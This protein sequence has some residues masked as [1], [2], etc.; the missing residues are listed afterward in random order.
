MNEF[1][2]QS[3]WSRYPCGEMQI[4]GFEKYGNKYDV[5]FSAYDN[6]R[7]SREPHI[8][9]CLD[10]IDFKGK[11]TLE[12]GLGLGADS[13]Q[14]IRR[15]AIWSG[16]DLTAESVER[17]RIRFALRRLPFNTLKQGSVLSIPFDANSFDI[18]FSHGVL[19]HV[20][21]IDRAQSEIF[22]VLKSGGELIVMLYSKISL[23]YLM[24]ISF[25]RRL[26]LLFL[27]FLNYDPGGIYGQHIAN[28]RA[29]G[30]GRYLYMRNFIHKNTDGPLNPYSKVYDLPTVK[31]AFSNFRVVRAYKQFMHAPPL[32]VG[33]LPFERLL[34][35][36]L[37]V[38]MKPL[39]K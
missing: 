6:F 16:I 19:H 7:Y 39:K 32:P 27:Y 25:V 13:E 37:W 35:W 2:I 4:G 20:P 11:H 31:R 23:N 22:R 30:L 34:G 3:F 28:A 9:R 36:H 26:G 29:M 17:V 18:V 1:E 38:H 14:I 24:S 5:F 10:K 21:D 15:G 8:L 33:W 12:I